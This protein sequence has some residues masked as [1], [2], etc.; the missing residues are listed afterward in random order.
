MRNCFSLISVV[1]PFALVSSAWAHADI[2]VSRAGD[3]IVT[4]GYDFDAAPGSEVL[5]PPMRVFGYDFG[6]VPGQ[7]YFAG[8]PG[9]VSLAG[10]FPA[11]TSFTFSVLDDL[12]FWTGSGFAAAPSGESLF[13]EKGSFGVSV[14]TGETLPKAGHTIGTTS[15]ALSGQP[16]HEHLDVTIFGAGGGFSPPPADGVY[17]LTLALQ[18]SGGLLDSEPIWVVY[19][20]GADEAVH[21]EAIDW[22]QGNL[23]PE[24]STLCL[25]G[26]GCL[27]MRRRRVRS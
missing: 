22:V 9:V 17:L 15:G 16:L 7:P 14:G 19:N 5:S 3:Q 20:L 27:A 18:G 8:D 2:L 24:P 13:I 6:E 23:V 10:T 21:D 1:L 11:G 25:L 4:G 26:A 12:R